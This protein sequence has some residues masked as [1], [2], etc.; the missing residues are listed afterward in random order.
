M[1]DPKNFGV[2]STELARKL[3]AWL[4]GPDHRFQRSHARLALDKG[5]FTAGELT[6]LVLVAAESLLQKGKD[7]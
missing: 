3:A 1:L 4:I 6:Y 7:A 5:A 2:E